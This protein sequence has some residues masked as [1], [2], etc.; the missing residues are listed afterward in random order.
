MNDVGRA[1]LAL[2]PVLAEKHPDGHIGRTALMKYMYFLQ[3]I[4]DVPLGYHFSMYSYGP[5]DSDVL[6]DLSSAEALSVVCSTP[7]SFSGGYGYRIQPGP[8]AEKMKAANE[9]FLKEHSSDIDWL[10]TQFAGFNSADLELASTIIYV[11]REF[12]EEHEHRPL[13]EVLARVH[14]IKPH[15]STDRIQ[16][17]LDSLRSRGLLAAA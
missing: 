7:V 1:R 8:N 9:G 15:F 2:I 11:D 5:F 6:S 10:L 14:E 16:R 13:A 17:S 3:A 12:S 4:R